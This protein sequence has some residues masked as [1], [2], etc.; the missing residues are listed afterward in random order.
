MLNALGV[1]EFL[2]A[3]SEHLLVV[4]PQGRDADEQKR[5]QHNPEDAQATSRELREG[6]DG[7]K[8]PADKM[9]AEGYAE[10][11]GTKVL[12]WLNRY[13]GCDAATE[14]SGRKLDLS[15]LKPHWFYDGYGTA[16]AVP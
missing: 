7:H 10:H 13:T 5:T 6:S 4:E 1:L 12:G 8:N 3:E 9:L 16:K 15:R 11:N 14:T 2:F